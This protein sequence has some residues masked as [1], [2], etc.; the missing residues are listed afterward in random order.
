MS[1]KTTTPPEVITEAPPTS[2][3]DLRLPPKSDD[4]LFDIEKIRA[5]QAPFLERFRSKQAPS[6]YPKHDYCRQCGM[7]I[8]WLGPVYHDRIV[9]IIVKLS[10]RIGEPVDDIL[11]RFLKHLG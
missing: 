5:A 11:R 4:D 1:V 9:D 3:G 7:R 8:D 10:R 2:I 6:A